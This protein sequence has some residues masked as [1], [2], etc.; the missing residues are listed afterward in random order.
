MIKR[1]LKEPFGKAGLTVAVLALV[2]AMAGGA[3]AAGG[4]TKSQEKQVTK[5][6]KKY[7][8][9]PGA[10]GETGPAGAA[11][12]NGN[13]GTNGTN[14]TNGSSGASVTG[15]PIAS[16]SSDCTSKTG[17]VKYTLSGTST[18]VCNGKNGE[19]GFTETLP[20]GKTETGGWSAGSFGTT[21]PLVSLSFAI[22]LEQEVVTKAFLVPAVRPDCSTLSG[23]A[24]VQCEEAEAN[25]TGSATAPEAEPG[26]LCVYDAEA[27]GEPPTGAVFLNANGA[28]M[29]PGGTAKAGGPGALFFAQ[30]TGEEEAGGGSF[31]VTAPT[32]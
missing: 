28:F 16:G 23:A 11:G 21:E 22:P 14:G 15:V 4:L 25:C 29:A 6:A 8:G 17:G 19:T 3:Y 32:S 12:K 27:S 26:S 7:A 10:P 31:A 18:N 13:D 5:I 30:F 20:A 9:K 24:K 2:V 1:R